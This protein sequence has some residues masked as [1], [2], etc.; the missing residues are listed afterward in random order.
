MEF[1]DPYEKAVVPEEVEESVKESFPYLTMSPEEWVARHSH[2]VGSFGICKWQ[3]RDQQ[4]KVWLVRAYEFMHD[5][6]TRLR[7][8]R[9]FLTVE[10]Q[11]E[12][13]RIESDPHRSL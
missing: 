12:I 11:R 10:E 4:L 7:L 1:I 9:E 13:E 5:K 2:R 6:E 8:R 3:Y